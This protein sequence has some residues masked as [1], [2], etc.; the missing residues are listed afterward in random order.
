MS[1]N[2]LVYAVLNVSCISPSERRRRPQFLLV[3]VTFLANYTS[4]ML[5]MH[6]GWVDDGLIVVISTEDDLLSNRYTHGL[7]LLPRHES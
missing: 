4:G 3:L 6:S 7:N 1:I 2:Y 5:A